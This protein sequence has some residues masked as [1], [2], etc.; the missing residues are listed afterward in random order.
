MQQN[1]ELYLAHSVSLY[2]W[3]IDDALQTGKYLVWYFIIIIDY[4]LQT[5][6]RCFLQWAGS[7]FWQ[8]SYCGCSSVV[9]MDDVAP[10]LV[11]KVIQCTNRLFYIL[12]CNTEYI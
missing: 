9:A 8:R 3:A 12:L 5:I 11:Q 2:T 10:P 6:R 7:V 1:V 4:S